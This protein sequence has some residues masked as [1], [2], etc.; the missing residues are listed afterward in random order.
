M[1]LTKEIRMRK[2]TTLKIPASHL[3]FDKS[4]EL[5]EVPDFPGYLATSDGRILIVRQV[6]GYYVDRYAI[7]PLTVNGKN[8][9]KTTHS[10]I[11]SAFKGKRPDGMQA[12]HN[13]GNRNNNHISNLRWGTRREN[14]EDKYKHGT[15]KTNLKIASEIMDLKGKLKRADIANK[16]GISKS[17]VSLIHHKKRLQEIV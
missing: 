12:C 16:Y 9:G 14:I 7:T 3:I 13:D 8:Y 17:M 2:K 5:K 6:S 1:T 15:A 11:L 10:L 4:I